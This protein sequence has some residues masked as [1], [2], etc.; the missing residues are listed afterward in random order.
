MNEDT[1]EI[2]R[3]KFVNK[4]HS[5][6]D[7]LFQLGKVSKADLERIVALQAESNL[8]FGDAAIRLGLIKE[9]DIQ[10]VLA[11]QFNYPYLEKSKSSFS[12]ELVAAYEP[13]SKQVEVF[14]ELRSQLIM[15]WFNKGF[16]SLAVLSCNSGEGASYVV[17]NLAILFSQLGERTLLI[18]ANLRQPRQ[19]QIFNVKDRK[20]LSDIIVS[21]AGLEKI[22]RLKEFNDLSILSAG[23]LPPNPQELLNHAA[24]SDLMV[25]VIGQYDV[26]LVDTAPAKSLADAQPVVACCGGALIVSKLHSTSMTD[27]KQTRDQVLVAGANLV[28][29]VVN[30]F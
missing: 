1:V 28:G 7:L 26:V 20:G 17:A 11:L 2:S 24:F 22:H 14:R 4:A 3:E 21:R 18:D 25:Q 10:Q 15:G 16:K 30:D 6:G 9:S 5:I 23:T 8:R 13:F 19:H 29:T 27:L 12:E